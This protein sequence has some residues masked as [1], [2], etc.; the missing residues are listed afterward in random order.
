M[1]FLFINLSVCCWPLPIVTVTYL[2]NIRQY[3]SADHGPERERNRERDRQTQRDR[4]RH[5]ER[6]YI[7]KLAP[8][9]KKPQN[10]SS[11]RTFVLIVCKIAHALEGQSAM[12]QTQS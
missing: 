1:W 12:I 9:K 11:R 2:Y 8:L 5:R 10:T 7:Y 6:L 3:S 4:E